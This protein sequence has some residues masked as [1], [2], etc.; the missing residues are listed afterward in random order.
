MIDLNTKTARLG[1]NS[2]ALLGAVAALYLG[3]TIFIPTVIALL[4]AAMLW[5]MTVWLHRRLRFRWNFACFI[6]VGGLVLVILLMTVGLSLVIPKLLQTV[7]RADEVNKQL[8][9]YE[10]FRKRLESLSPVP[11]D[12]TL[13]PRNP[14]STDDIRAFHYITEALQKSLPQILLNVAV[15]GSSYLWQLILIMFILLFLLL[16]GRMLSRRVVEIF[17]PSLEV[18]TSARRVLADMAGQVRTYLVWRTIINVG[19]AVTVGVVYNWAGLAQPWTWAILTAVLFYIPYLGP[20]IAGVFPLVDAFVSS[21]SLMV[22]LGILVFYTVV[23][24]LEGYLVFPV[25]MGRSME[26]NA[27]TVMLACLF[28]ELVWGIVGLF[29]AMPLMAAIKAICYHVPGWRPWA[30]LMSITEQGPDRPPLESSRPDLVLIDPAAE[31]LPAEPG[32]ARE[33]ETSRAQGL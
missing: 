4:L 28:W 26:L 31:A 5:P 13:F 12:E 8:E 2:L 29:L 23:T 3:R 1:L 14:Q 11:L 10:K 20:I 7:P 25:V 22:P 32:H 18:Q 6:V 21:P 16:E 15:Y 19:V 17:G 30:N 33:A 27:T 9:L 24:I